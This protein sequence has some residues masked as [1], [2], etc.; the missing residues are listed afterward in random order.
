MTD[1]T[2]TISNTGGLPD[3]GNILSVQ[4]V[5]SANGGN[6]EF[7]FDNIRITGDSALPVELTSFQAQATGNEVFLTWQTASEDQ[8]AGFEVQHQQADGAPFQTVGF[9]EGAG[10]TRVA[11]RY[12]YQVADL[13][14]GTH[15]FRLKQVDLDGG[16]SFSEV[17]EAMAEVPGTHMLGAAYPNPFN[18][19]TRFTLA[20]GRDQH[21]DI[22][23]YN[24]L[25]K[26]LSVLHTGTLT[27]DKVHTFTLDG[28]G[29]PS[30]VY[31][32]QVTG[33]QFRETR[34]VML[35]K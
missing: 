30:G 19:Q 32:Y 7:A 25:G 4:V 26:R 17:V 21:V 31:L 23:V 33:E 5:V 29:L 14:P 12:T 6:E 22:E 3:T 24:L 2:F 16:F 15:R 10:T 1:Y 20:V 34:R 35:V 28:V 11:Q 8:N 13:L 9:V 27:A 18:P